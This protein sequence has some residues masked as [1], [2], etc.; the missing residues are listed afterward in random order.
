MWQCR[1]HVVAIK[2]ALVDPRAIVKSCQLT[3]RIGEVIF[4]GELEVAHGELRKMPEL[5]VPLYACFRFSSV[6]PAAR[7]M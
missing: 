3:Q 2:P 6:S 5:L 7:V 4:S 1:S